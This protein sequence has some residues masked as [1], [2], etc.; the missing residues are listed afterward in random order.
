MIEMHGAPTTNGIR[1]KVTLDECG[2]DYRLH[3]VDMAARQ[4]K[5]ADFLALNPMGQTPVI[6]DDDPPGGGRLVMAQSV[7]IMFYLA[8]KSGRFLPTDPA[9]RARFWQPMM[10]AA[11]D[12]GPTYGA[13][14]FV[15]RI[16][17]PHAPTRAAL[18]GRLRDIYAVWDD[19]L[20]E[21]E[22]CAGDA[23][24]IADFA[25]FGIHARTGSTAP[26]AIE[27]ME[28]LARWA[29]AMNARPGVK[30][31]LDFG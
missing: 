10:Q 18:I 20:G 12:L 8:E 22:W 19:I 11:T 27:G 4:H 5:S 7:G 29:E 24:T 31:G 23:V 1:V 6:I 25:V 3:R 26:E 28:N 16:K 30:K 2:L 14:V 15:G 21:S 17:E 13:A 9:A